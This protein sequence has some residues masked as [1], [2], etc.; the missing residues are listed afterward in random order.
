MAPL[1]KLG[2][3]ANHMTL[4]RGACLLMGFALLGGCNLS[5]PLQ[6][7]APQEVSHR[8][9]SFEPSAEAPQS[10]I[11]STLIQRRSVIGEDSALGD[12]ARVAL[13]SGARP[14]E[15]KLRTAKLRAEAEN[16]NWL[17]TIGP[18]V[19]L[20]SLGDVL[21]SLV[22]D[23]VLF[24][25]GRK[26]AE[27]EFAW[28][29]V[30]V[31]AV[32]LS[33]D[34]NNRVFTALSLYVTALRGQEK[35][36]VGDR[37]MGQMRAFNRIVAGRVTGGVSNLGDLRM[38]EDKTQSILSMRDTAKDE[39]TAALAE[40]EAM[41][42]TRFDGKPVTAL[43]VLPEDRGAPLD[44]LKAD[45]EAKRSVAQATIQ[46]ASLLPGLNASGTVSNNGTSATIEASG[47][48]GIGLGTGGKLKAIEASK[49]TA[50]RQ[51]A[52]ARE[53][54][55]RKQSRLE[56]R[57]ASQQRQQAEAQRLAQ[58]GQETFR[59]FQAQFRAGQRSVLE[60]V[61]V[62]EQSVRRALEGV[63]A[64][65]DVILAQL[66]LARDMGLLADGDAI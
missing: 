8:T 15:A 48:T 24:D 31:A 3:G 56:Q 11:L 60:V 42:G 59:L 2:F 25:H 4:R 36:Q 6:G 12:V 55:A 45:A 49:E 40:L 35:A 33:Q 23:Q 34:M 5:L 29:D 26:K 21:A 20:T 16:K 19:S 53:D 46:R 43:A 27:R 62:Y 63:D 1:G 37:A 17:P 22:V 39:A 64:K 47:E 14:S 50:R 10:E 54:A 38:V 7:R 13:S 58:Q 61:N 9:S 57:I 32:T 65:Y 41:T 30:E 18:V 44:V 28:A 51:V 52:E 66:E